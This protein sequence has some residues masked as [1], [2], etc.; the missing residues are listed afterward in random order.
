MRTFDRLLMYVDDV[1]ATSATTG[2]HDNM[3][4]GMCDICGISLSNSRCDTC[5]LCGA[6]GECTCFDDGDY[7]GEGIFDASSHGFWPVNIDLAQ[8]HFSAAAPAAPATDDD[9][10]D[11]WSEPRR[12]GKRKLVRKK[13]K[14]RLHRKKVSKSVKKSRADGSSHESFDEFFPQCF[15]RE[16]R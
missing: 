11:G 12:R 5:G 9:S 4:F 16:L 2:V 15:S 13:M 8:S 7:S 10:V 6:C 3:S 14:K 1:S